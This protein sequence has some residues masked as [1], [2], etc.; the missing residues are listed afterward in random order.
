MGNRI[1]LVRNK[2]YFSQFET[3]RIELSKYL[4]IDANYMSINST[5][6]NTIFYKDTWYVGGYSLDFIPTIRITIRF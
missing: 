1:S 2:S 3:P 4:S 5:A 6:Y